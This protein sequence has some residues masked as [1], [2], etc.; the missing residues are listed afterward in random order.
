[1][2]RG[3]HTGSGA[4]EI[5][6]IDQVCKVPPVASEEHGL[7]PGIPV[8]D[9]GNVGSA[10]VRV[11]GA[12][13]QDASAPTV[14]LS[15][16]HYG[17]APTVRLPLAPEAVDALTAAGIQGGL[18]V[19]NIIASIQRGQIVSQAQPGAPTPRFAVQRSDYSEASDDSVP[20]GQT[21][22]FY[23]KGSDWNLNPMPSGGQGNSSSWR[24]IGTPK[25]VVDKANDVLYLVALVKYLADSDFDLWVRKFDAATDTEWTYVADV[26]SHDLAALVGR[27]SVVPF[28]VAACFFRGTL[29][30]FCG[31]VDGSEVPLFT[32]RIGGDAGDDIILDSS[33]PVLAEALIANG[34]SF[35][36]LAVDA[37]DS[38]F[39]LA[40]SGSAYITNGDPTRV[41][42]AA[43]SPDGTNWSTS[44]DDPRS[45][46][47]T[48]IGE[49]R[50]VEG[51]LQGNITSIKFADDELNGWACTD[52]GEVFASIDGGLTWG[53]QIS[54]VDPQHIG[55]RILRA[56]LLNYISVV[57]ATVVYICGGEGL[58][59][60]TTDGGATWVVKRYGSPTTLVLDEDFVDLGTGDIA[61]ARNLKSMAWMGDGS[62]GWIVGD[63]GFVLKATAGGAAF[64][65]IYDWGTAVALTSVTIEDDT[66]DHQ[67]ILVGG[68]I[69]VFDNATISPAL[70]IEARQSVIARIAEA[71]NV[72]GEITY[73]RPIG[74]DIVA[75]QKSG[76]GSEYT[77]ALSRKG[78]VLKRTD[79]DL[80]A[81][82]H[83]IF[84]RT[85]EWF[86]PLRVIDDDTVIVRG[87][88]VD[89][90]VDGGLS[91]NTLEVP[92]HTAGS[93]W[94]FESD[95]G[96]VGG[97]KS[98]AHGLNVANDRTH[99]DVMA[100]PN[101]PGFLLSLSNK[102]KGYVEAYRCDSQRQPWFLV[103][104]SIAFPCSADGD[105]PENVPMTALSTDEYGSIMLM[106]G[107]GRGDES[108]AP[109]AAPTHTLSAN[110]AG[111]PPGDWLYVI[112]TRDATTKRETLVSPTL[113]VPIGSTSNVVLSFA[114]AG[115]GR[116]TVI[117][118]TDNEATTFKYLIA[119]NA[120]ATGYT[121]SAALATTDLGPPEKEDGGI[122]SLDGG[123]SW[124]S[125]DD[126]SLSF[127]LGRFST[128]AET[129]EGI[130][131]LANSAMR[132]AFC[133]RIFA[134]TLSPGRDVPSGAQTL[135][136]W[137]AREFDGS[138]S[139]THF[140]PIIPGVPQ[141]I[142]VDKVKVAILGDARPGDSWT[143]PTTSDYPA[144]NLVVES[145]SVVL[146]SI[147]NAADWRLLWDR[148]SAAS[149]ALYGPGS[150]FV[151]TGFAMFGT[152]FKDAVL[153]ISVPSWDSGTFPTSS[154]DYVQ[155]NLSS[156]VATYDD[157]T[158]I[159]GVGNVVRLASADRDLIPDHWKAAYGQR[160]F[161]YS[162]FSGVAYDIEGNTRDNI[163]IARSS[164]VST[165]GQVQVF[166]NQFFSKLES[167]TCGA[168][169]NINLQN[170]DYKHTRL[171]QLTIPRS[172]SG[173]GIVGDERIIGK[174]IIGTFVGDTGLASEPHDRRRGVSLGYGFTAI[175][176]T[177]ETVGPHGVGSVRNFGSLRRFVLPVDSARSWDM[178]MRTAGFGDDIR[179]AFCFVF[180]GDD[181]DTA[182]LV[183]RR[184]GSDYIGLAG[185]RFSAA[186]ELVQV[187]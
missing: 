158:A 123:R 115:T 121:N 20:T 179:Q 116:E 28:D 68:T 18:T 177:E 5:F 8:A 51:R 61:K 90:T 147:D 127:P 6:L 82:V 125:R 57:S 107:I 155:F 66:P 167:G 16:P 144:A 43:F 89:R 31:G 94:F 65:E 79:A 97:G 105:L 50:V 67:T 42:Q 176:S 99:Q 114:A 1:M 14:E 7:K 24:Y 117:Y 35:N 159:S 162:N 27:A 136:T 109:P 48:A 100:I 102:T 87:R 106:A 95:R 141:W 11:T 73:H 112:T 124:L 92:Q 101:S 166:G 161:L 171:V 19:E 26:P 128:A 53:Q 81:R 153:R 75:M 149:L 34:T 21:V 138:A 104:A 152:N 37:N 111:L 129:S 184:D 140:P 181:Q 49:F 169:T 113:H 175:P 72:G 23:A 135:K 63:G 58:V 180:S 110:G 165:P 44:I 77:Y 122:I 170:T 62:V 164:V 9:A 10:I 134:V 47:L 45:V 103:N 69:G 186:F 60:A 96:V 139:P 119:V 157:V 137:T 3:P 78:Y 142:G 132:R 64:T 146:K 2:A 148:Q 156:V 29:F 17:S 93:L 154:S 12:L 84:R 55:T 15:I 59:L 54:P 178:D 80:W 36:A 46:E 182:V 91:W 88:L 4:K 70:S 133:G 118:R 13:R 151:V 98:I 30:I 126:P 173:Q 40:I 108:V 163:I 52:L 85:N 83:R 172:G 71:D 74:D 56:S 39:C 130:M 131:P 33:N 187:P 22:D 76:S 160:Y 32:F 25:L 168:T 120:A 174:P 150:H 183:R 145:P 41:V 143:L 86:D 38:G 185:D